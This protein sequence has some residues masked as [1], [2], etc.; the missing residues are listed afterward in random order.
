MSAPATRLVFAVATH[1]H[2]TAGAVRASMTSYEL[3]CWSYWLNEAQREMQEHAQHNHQP[4][5]LELDVEAEIAAWP[6][7]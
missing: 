6:S 3:M 5:P 2:M 7:R 1:L 4:A